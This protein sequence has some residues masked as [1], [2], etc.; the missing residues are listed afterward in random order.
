MEFTS[1]SWQGT[2]ENEPGFEVRETEARSERMS[3]DGLGVE[4]P[5]VANGERFF[6]KEKSR[7]FS[8]LA[9]TA[10]E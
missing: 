6:G 10:G 2:K 9:S 8:N 7:T 3:G 1:F 4:I 5:R